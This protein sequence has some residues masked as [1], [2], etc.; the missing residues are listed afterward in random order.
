MELVP[1]GRGRTLHPNIVVR[2]VVKVDAFRNPSLG[3][4]P[5]TAS[6]RGAPPRGLRLLV[7]HTVRLGLLQEPVL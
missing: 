4:A 3:H 5:I 6:V 1:A 2:I 7:R